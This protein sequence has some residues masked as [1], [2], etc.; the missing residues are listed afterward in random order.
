MKQI[1]PLIMKYK[2]IISYLFFGVVTTLVNWMVYALMVRL[3]Q[4]DLSAVESTDNVVFSIFSGSSGKSLTLLFIANLVA[5]VVS[6]LVAF[7]TNKL[8]VFDSKTWRLGVVLHELWEFVASRLLTG[9]FEW[10]GIPAL[11]MLGMKQSLLGIEGFWAKALVSV[12]VVVLNY[13]FSKFIVFKNKSNKG[14]E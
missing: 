9:L 5:W 10:F 11:V 3:L 1:K 2:E 7:V 14:G 12:L 4:V 13:V 8:W 6:V